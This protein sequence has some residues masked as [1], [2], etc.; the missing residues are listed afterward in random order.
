MRPA[1][2]TRAPRPASYV[3]SNDKR[4]QRLRPFSH[5]PVTWFRNPYTHVI[6]VRPHDFHWRFMRILCK[7]Q[8]G[9]IWNQLSRWEAQEDARPR[10]IGL[11]FRGSDGRCCLCDTAHGPAPERSRQGSC[12]A[13]AP[14]PQLLA[15]A[16]AGQGQGRGAAARRR[17]AG[18]LLGAG[19]RRTADQLGANV[20]G[21]LDTHRACCSLQF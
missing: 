12:P 11:L 7:K 9:T 21:L 2:P 19:A 16:A 18:Q 15:V 8:L 17:A 14:S 13:A 5:S 10:P 3:L 4:L 6:L 1:V 20:Q